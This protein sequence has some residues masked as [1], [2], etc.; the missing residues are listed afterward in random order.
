VEFCQSFIAILCKRG[1]PTRQRILSEFKKGKTSHVTIGE[2]AFHS[3]R[4]ILQ[5]RN[6]QCASMEKVVENMKTHVENL[7]NIVKDREGQIER[8]KQIIEDLNSQLRKNT[9]T[10]DDLQRLLIETK[11]AADAK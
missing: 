7:E 4:V 6:E 10:I 3:C 9:A 11:E 1:Y 5:R 2:V 8:T